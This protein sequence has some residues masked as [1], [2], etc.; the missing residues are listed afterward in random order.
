MPGVRLVNSTRQRLYV[1]GRTISTVQGPIK[2]FIVAQ[3]PGAFTVAGDFDDDDDY[4]I[5]IPSW[6]RSVASTA[7]NVASA[8]GIP[9][10]GAIKS[11]AEASGLL[12]GKKKA[13]PKAA[14]P[15]AAR[16]AAPRQLAMRAPVQRR[17]AV[18]HLPKGAKI[19]KK[20]VEVIPVAPSTEGAGFID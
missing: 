18:R 6:L 15:K 2:I 12:K 5:G 14:I 16:A 20:F 8:A 10:A 13:A 7:L 17:S 3:D 11:V 1:R 9:G 4:E 19:P